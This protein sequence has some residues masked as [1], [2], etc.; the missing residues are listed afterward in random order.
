M[1]YLTRREWLKAAT[2]L[3]VA[4]Q[5]QPAFSQAGIVAP[6]PPYLPWVNMVADGLHLT[7]IEQANRIQQIAGRKN[8]M[9]DEYSLGGV[10]TELEVAFAGLLGKET[11]VFMPTGTLANHLAV[12]ALAS[13]KR[14]PGV[15]V[16]V[17]G[18]SHLYNDTGDCLTTL[19][20]LNMIP[21]GQD[22]A[23]FTR[24]E[25]EAECRRSGGGRVATQPGV[26]VIESPVRRRSGELFDP[27]ELHQVTAFA[28]SNGMGLHLD[29]A[30]LLIASAYTGIA[31]AALAAPFDTVYVSLYKGLN[32]PSG[33]I[34]AGP[35]RLLEGMFHARRMFGSGLPEAWPFAASALEDLPGFVE[36]MQAA[37]ATSE[38]VY[39]FLERDGFTLRRVPRGTNI[40]FL[41]LGS[42]DASKVQKN[43]AASRVR[44]G[45]LPGAA[46]ELKLL[47]N[48]SWSRREPQ[49][50][51]RTLAEA[52]RRA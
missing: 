29:G 52:L 6:E 19:S 11:A 15:R 33:A 45:T 17:P 46:R 7:P 24:A 51:A 25:V 50:L 44:V 37:V 16:L 1:A 34:L 41:D 4:G 35:H 22:S 39:G 40:A 49:E 30:R 31:P 47:V 42:V 14:G 20:G 3:A 23:T 48:E 8:F 10:V 27:E 43:L 2:A 28:R 12:R 21:L 38:H 9:P 36:R 5:V 32:A 13:E 18:T 26:L